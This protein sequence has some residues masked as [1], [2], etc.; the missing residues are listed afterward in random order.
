MNKPTAN[1]TP[2]YTRQHSRIPTLPQLSA[3]DLLAAGKT[4]QEAAD[5]LQLHRTTVTKWRLYDPVFQAALNRRRAEV[6]GAAADRLRSL[7][8]KALDALAAALEDSAHPGRLKA[9]AELLRLA[10]PTGSALD[11]GPTDPE[12]IVRGIVRQ[13]RSA[14]PGPLDGL[15]DDG[16]NL[17]P[18]D[19]HVERVWRE[20][21]ARAEETDPAA[22]RGA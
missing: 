1:G 21:E 19:Q 14:A 5:L 2:V 10:P 11:I 12:Q 17:P 18:L 22:A 20:L 3:I 16:K 15:L 13:R 8:P 6:W 4:D 9:A 7:I